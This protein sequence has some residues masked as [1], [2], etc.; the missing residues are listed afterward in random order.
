MAYPLA[1]LLGIAVTVL[2]GPSI[3]AWL[4]ERRRQP[5]RPP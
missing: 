3:I 2:W 4:A 5:E 1:I